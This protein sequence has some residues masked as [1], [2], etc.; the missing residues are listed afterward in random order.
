MVVSRRLVF[1]VFTFRVIGGSL[2]LVLRSWV[3]MF[4]F[5]C[6]WLLTLGVDVRFVAL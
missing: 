4:G 2:T 5:A 6:C 3:G 1:T